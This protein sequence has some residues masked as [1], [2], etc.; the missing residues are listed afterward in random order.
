MIPGALSAVQ[1]ISQCTVETH[2][3]HIKQKLGLDART[4]IS[5]RVLAATIG[6][7]VR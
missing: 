2:V 4:Q 7:R 1:D 3:D 6:A 5:A